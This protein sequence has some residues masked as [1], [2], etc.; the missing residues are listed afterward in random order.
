[1]VKAIDKGA[2]FIISTLNDVLDMSRMESGKLRV[3]LK[4]F[5]AVAVI[6]DAI[7]LLELQ[8]Q[9]RNL[10]VRWQAVPMPSMLGDAKRLRQV[11]TN[12]LANAIRHAPEHSEIAVE[13]KT[14]S[15]SDGPAVRITITD[16]GEGVPR[17]RQEL[18]FRCF[19]QPGENVSAGHGLAISSAL[20][21][22]MG[23]EIGFESQPGRTSFWVE[24]RQ[25]G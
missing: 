21:N 12:I 5:D 8:A 19:S 11:L 13:M 10:V 17:S 3:P 7:D 18:L 23:G 14:I 9:W 24:L 1:M 2:E 20:M 4:P 25:A 6:S 15:W 22:A 16:F